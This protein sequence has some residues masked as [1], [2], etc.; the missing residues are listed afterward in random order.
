MNNLIENFFTAKAYA[1]IGV[2][3]NRGKFGNKVL[4]CLNERFTKVYPI[5]PV[6]PE[7]E[8][9]PCVVSVLELPDGVESLSVVTPPAITEKII[10][11]AHQK[12]IKHIWMQPGAESTIAIEKCNQYG[13]E[14]IAGGP[15][16]LVKLGWFATHND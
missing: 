8:G 14:V 3:N 9:I 12:G 4:R 2:S 11:E 5:H 10:E 1:V 15:C 6:Q 16:I 7:I 13:I